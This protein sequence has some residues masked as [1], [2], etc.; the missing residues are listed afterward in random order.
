MEQTNNVNNKFNF[1]VEKSK[2]KARLL[3]LALEI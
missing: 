1:A 2:S 3:K